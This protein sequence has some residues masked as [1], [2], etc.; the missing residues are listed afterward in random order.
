MT[1]TGGAGSAVAGVLPAYATRALLVGG[2]A[3]GPLF[4]VWPPRRCSP[5]TVST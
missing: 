3:A 2:A 1:S 4:G 5:A